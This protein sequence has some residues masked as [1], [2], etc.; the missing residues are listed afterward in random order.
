MPDTV[1]AVTL[2]GF[3]APR[4]TSALLAVV[5]A[6][7]DEFAAPPRAV[8]LVALAGGYGRSGTGEK[9]PAVVG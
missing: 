6:H 8:A 4:T 2:V 5:A 1:A 3:D 7:R 9:L